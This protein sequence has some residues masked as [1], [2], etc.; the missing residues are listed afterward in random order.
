LNMNHQ[1][2]YILGSG[3]FGRRAYSFLQRQCH[4]PDI[5]VVD[6]SPGQL[7]STRVDGGHAIAMDA[8]SFLTSPKTNLHPDDWIVPAVPIHVSF[9]WVWQE[10][11][12]TSECTALPVPEAI[13]A[14][15]PNP[16]RGAEGQ[17]YISNADFI[18]PDDCP[19]PD[20]LCTVT[21]EPR[22]QVLCD[23][24]S[25]LRLP[26]YHSTCIVSSQLAP[27]VGGF[28]WRSLLRALED[29]KVH[30][31]RILV[32]TACKC[33]GVMHAFMHQPNQ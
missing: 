12:S 15:L 19:E 24:L 30:P 9:E 3:H 31:G 26:D 18:C 21:G 17:L 16:M 2:T 28:Q 1:K 32:S 5:H 10:L 22:P 27:G 6:H 14:R 7:E 29:I 11:K 8:I 13:A 23:T 25:S 33:H 20:D 4:P